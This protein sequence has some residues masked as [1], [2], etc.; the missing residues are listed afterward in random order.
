MCY[1]FQVSYYW[2]GG[3]PWRGESWTTGSESERLKEERRKEDDG[4][5]ENGEQWLNH[6]V[7]VGG[8]IIFHLDSPCNISNNPLFL[9]QTNTEQI[10]HEST[11]STIKAEA[12]NVFYIIYCSLKARAFT[13]LMKLSLTGAAI[14]ATLLLYV[15]CLSLVCVC[16]F[17]HV[18]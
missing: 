10:L 1:W 18:R 17:S 14:L 6:G 7:F 16:F 15:L 5:G 12:G 2:N 8:I 4:R 3:G 13:Q 9:C 11:M